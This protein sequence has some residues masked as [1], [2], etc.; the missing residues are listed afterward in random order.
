MV[1]AYE[2]SDKPIVDSRIKIYTHG[3]LNGG[4]FSSF[5]ARADQHRNSGLIGR[6]MRLS[7]RCLEW[8]VSKH[9][10]SVRYYRPESYSP[11]ITHGVA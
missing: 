4:P 5:G 11:S 6:L 1:P 9:H 7:V 10:K 8:R 2:W 3:C